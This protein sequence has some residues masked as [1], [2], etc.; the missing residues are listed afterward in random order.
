MLY[1]PWPRSGRLLRHL[2]FFFLLPARSQSWRSKAMSRGDPLRAMGR[3]L[4]PSLDVAPPGLHCASLRRK[5]NAAATGSAASALPGTVHSGVDPGVRAGAQGRE[6]A[7]AP[8]ARAA[9]S[10]A[11]KD[12]SN[13][14]PFRLAGVRGRLAPGVDASPRQTRQ[15]RAC[16]FRSES[17]PRSPS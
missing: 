10:P 9:H 15:A 13:H 11:V 1:G 12:Q 2:W 16:T 8:G 6:H 14:N 17:D 7:P 3:A 4:A 5:K